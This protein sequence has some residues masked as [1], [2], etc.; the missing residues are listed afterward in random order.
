M[1]KKWN[2][3]CPVCNKLTYHKSEASL[4]LALKQQRP[5]LSC[6]HESQRRTA[7][8]QRSCPICKTLLN[9]K[10]AS[11]YFAAIKKNSKCNTCSKLGT[12]KT[13]TTS[14]TPWKRNCSKCESIIYYSTKDSLRRAELSKRK[15]RNCTDAEHRRW[16]IEHRKIKYPRYNSNACVLF[17]QINDTFKWNGQHAENGGEFYIKELGYWV[18]YYEPNLNLVIEYDEKHHKNQK[19]NLHDINRQEKIIKH[20]N[21]K[22]YRIHETQTFSDVCN[23]LNFQ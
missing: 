4:K 18:D 9:Y 2:R 12:R 7:P 14:K 23:L 15:C 22:F 13:K 16:M 1:I 17:E 6:N 5:C 3:V 20:L 19:K 8:Y 11:N 10:H 21:C